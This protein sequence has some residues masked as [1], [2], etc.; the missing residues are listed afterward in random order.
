[1]ELV[2]STGERN[3]KLDEET[4]IADIKHVPNYKLK[5][6]R[7][8]KNEGGTVRDTADRYR[9]EWS[10]GR[11]QRGRRGRGRGERGGRGRGERGRGQ[12]RYLNR[13]NENN[14]NNQTLQQTTSEVVSEENWDKEC[15]DSLTQKT[16]ENEEEK[17][18][19]ENHDD[20]YGEDHEHENY[21]Q[22]GDEEEYLE[23]NED[24]YLLEE[25]EAPVEGNIELE[26]NLV[27]TSSEDEDKRKRMV[28]FKLDDNQTDEAANLDNEKKDVHIEPS[29]KLGD[30][31]VAST[32]SVE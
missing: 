27:I 29:Q 6:L 31:K 16:A 15:F 13:N 3:C 7:P 10:R 8:S 17:E 24:N 30:K 28:T 12:G 14:E 11:G 19:K 18:N 5:D 4:K 9:N 20:D 22:E 21:Y 32:K 25:A 2:A 23:T 1:M 26:E